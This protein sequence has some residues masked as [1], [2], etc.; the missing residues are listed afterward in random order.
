MIYAASEQGLKVKA[1]PG[2]T[3]RCPCCGGDVL[4]KCG[5]IKVWHWAHVSGSDCDPWSEGETEW[6][7]SW[8]A[9]V[10]PE[11]QEVTM[12]PHRADI[13]GNRGVVVELQHSPISVEEIAERERFYR[14]MMWVFDAS[15]FRKNLKFHARTNGEPLRVRVKFLTEWNGRPAGTEEEC[16]Y[17]TYAIAQTEGASVRKLETLNASY[18]TFRWKWPRLSV[19]SATAPRF[20]D[21]GNGQLFDV[22]KVGDETPCGGWG[23]FLWRHEFLNRYLSSVLV[24]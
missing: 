14:R 1:E 18:H 5:S 24:S 12:K 4:A 10:V 9:E 17:Q 2:G 16:D 6:H 8:K 3:A 19:A 7:L 20:F 22:R 11:A 13:V 23:H 21:L 15:G